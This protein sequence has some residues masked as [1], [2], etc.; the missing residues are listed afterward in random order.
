[1]EKGLVVK[2]QDGGIVITID[3]E[4]LAHAFEYCAGNLN[5]HTFEPIDRVFD[6]VTFASDVVDQLL[7]EEEDGTFPV[8]VMLTQASLRAA[9]Q[10]SMGIE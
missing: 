2:A 10:G 5:P 3:A 4:T 9:D 7:K 1:M 6:H 8:D